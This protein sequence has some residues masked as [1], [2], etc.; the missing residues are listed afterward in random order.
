MFDYA[1]RKLL[2]CRS[3]QVAARVQRAAEP[4]TDVGGDE[5]TRQYRLLHEYPTVLVKIACKKC[6]RSGQYRKGDLIVEYGA[7]Q[8]L[9]NM[10]NL[11]AKCERHGNYSDWCGAYILDQVER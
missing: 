7:S 9:P 11:I 2:R 3:R 10:L 4:A 8:N 6:S 5:M 1:N